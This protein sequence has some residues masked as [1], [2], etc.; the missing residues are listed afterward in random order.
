MARFGSTRIKERIDRD[1]RAATLQIYI[2]AS[3]GVVSMAL[4][5]IPISLIPS[6]IIIALFAEIYLADWVY[7]Q[8]SGK[9]AQVTADAHIVQHD[10]DIL[11]EMNIERSAVDS[12]VQR[13]YAR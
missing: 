9:A 12:V 2:N 7:S 6:Y 4:V 10:L 8:L 5:L 3:F 11:S 13:Q 1:V